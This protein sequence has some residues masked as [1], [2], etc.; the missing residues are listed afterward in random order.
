MNQAVWENASKHLNEIC[1]KDP[2][3]FSHQHIIISYHILNCQVLFLHWLTCVHRLPGA[4]RLLWG[5]AVSV[6][7]YLQLPDQIVFGVQLQLQLVDESVSL[8][9]LLDLQLQSQLKIPQSAG[10][11][12]DSHVKNT[13]WR[14]RKR[15]KRREEE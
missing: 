5:A 14:R 6:Q 4:D 12:R 11:L 13:N 7:F 15:R 10:A 2:G 9:E 8:S 3:I 1:N